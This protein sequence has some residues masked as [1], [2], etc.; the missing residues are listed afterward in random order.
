[1]DSDASKLFH[2]VTSTLAW[3]VAYHQYV[4]NK[5]LLSDNELPEKDK[6]SGGCL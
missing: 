4:L 6:G 2:L 1:M 3:H 5:N